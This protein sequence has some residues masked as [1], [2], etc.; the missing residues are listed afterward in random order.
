MLPQCWSRNSQ[1]EPSHIAYPTVITVGW[2]VATNSNLADAGNDK[3]TNSLKLEIFILMNYNRCI[4]R[5]DSSGPSI[6]ECCTYPMSNLSDLR[7][8][9]LQV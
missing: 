6:I 7:L 1:F 3:E 2:I 4:L 5:T 9:Q 8:L